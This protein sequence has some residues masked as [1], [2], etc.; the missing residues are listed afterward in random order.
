MK[1][2]PFF[3]KIFFITLLV[4]IVCCPS[5]LFAAIGDDK[6]EQYPTVGIAKP[7][8]P[9]KP[10]QKAAGKPAI[11]ISA[12]LLFGYDDNV[13]LDHY[14]GAGSLF[15]Q[16]ALGLSSKYKINDTF[17]VRGSYDLTAINYLRFSD[18]NLLDNLFD[19]GLD[20]KIADDWTW[21][22][23]Y[24]PDIV[25]LPH[26]KFSEY[27]EQLFTTSLRQDIS[28]K[29]YQK[30]TYGIFTR[31]YPKWATRNNYGNA[32]LGDR[33]DLRNTAIHQIGFYL[34]K[35]LFLKEENTFYYN[36]SNEKYL[37]Y[38][39]YKSY[40]TRTTLIHFTTKKL[41]EAANFSYQYK[42]YDKRSVSDRQ[43]EDQRDHLFMFGGSV[44]YDITSY[45]TVGTTFNYRKNFSNEESENYRDYILS[46][47]VYC[48]F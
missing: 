46:S 15:F 33:R 9:A 25:G 34:G 27:N 43:G 1:K 37:R 18:T 2:R 39:D 24:R 23:D 28:K 32:I 44:F 48:R 45:L 41:Y 14:D 12:S 17:T 10:V 5:L 22:L 29:I 36:D 35:N 7:A 42:S 11:N 26:D 3:I 38:Y 6:E 4:E 8:V 31:H 21:S 19:I 47:G 40:I 30:I 13:R 16:E 20:V